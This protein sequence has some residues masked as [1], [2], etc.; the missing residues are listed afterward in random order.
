MSDVVETL[1][2]DEIETAK[3]SENVQG[4]KVTRAR[5]LS[6]LP[7]IQRLMAVVLASLL[8]AMGGALCRVV[9]ILSL[10]LA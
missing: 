1:T 2:S 10:S 3:I 9:A 6:E 8:T 5:M 7:R 4:D